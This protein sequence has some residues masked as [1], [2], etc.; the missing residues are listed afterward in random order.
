MFNFP[1]PW[2]QKIELLEKIRKF[3]INIQIHD[4]SL[5][6]ILKSENWDQMPIIT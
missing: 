5:K 1:Y 4:L 2:F 3:N 6:I